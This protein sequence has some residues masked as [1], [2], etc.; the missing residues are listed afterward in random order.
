MRDVFNDV[1]CD[2]CSEVM[3]FFAM[4]VLRFFAVFKPL[5]FMEGHVVIQAPIMKYR[6]KG[7]KL[8]YK[9]LTSALDSFLQGNSDCREH[10]LIDFGTEESVR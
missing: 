4:S 3:M 10:A 8:L 5:Q 2:V 9:T 7:S 6:Q 1:F